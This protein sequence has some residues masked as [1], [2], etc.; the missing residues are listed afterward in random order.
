[1]TDTKTV[2][3]KIP[4]VPGDQIHFLESGFTIGTRLEDWTGNFAHTSVRGETITLTQGIIDSS[5]DRVGNSWLEYVDD[6]EAQ[7]RRYSQ[8]PY[9]ARGPAPEGMT[10][11]EPGSA[12]QTLLYEARKQAIYDSVKDPIELAE[13][14]K[15][16]SQSP[17]GRN[18]PQTKNR[19]V[20]HADA[21]KNTN[22]DGW[23]Y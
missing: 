2:R 10:D 3:N 22:S 23:N 18:L 11:W 5:F 16:L 7:V 8:G 15:A 19:T 6:L 20:Y 21:P 1:M 14:L 12:E 17:L 9:F 4:V 13:K